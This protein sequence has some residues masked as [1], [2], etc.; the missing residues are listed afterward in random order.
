MNTIRIT[1]FKKFLVLSAIAIAL[2]APAR[3]GKANTILYGSTGD[4][5]TEGGGRL[6]LI[7][8]TAQTVT[9]IGD[10]GFGNL[11]GIAFDNSGVL[12]GVAGGATK[13][14][15]GTLMTIDPNTGA[16]TPIGTIGANIG[17][18]ALRFDSQNTLWGG[19]YDA[20]IT[21]GRLVTID[22]TNGNI[23]T[24]ITTSGSG[25]GLLPGLAFNSA[26]V[27]YGS[28]GG[29]FGHTE[30]VDLVDTTTGVLTP[31]PLAIADPSHP[32]SDL[33]FGSDGVLYG[34]SAFGQLYSID[35]TTGLLTF[36]F[37]T[38]ILKFSGLASQ[39][40]PGNS[41]GVPDA[42]SS[43]L[44]LGFALVA[45]IF[46]RRRLSLSN[47]LDQEILTDQPQT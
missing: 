28:R 6:Y 17:V 31:L 25:N 4:I 43:G 36:L 24:S 9:F 40:I 27:L 8:V 23:L 13:T 21:N 10:T 16:A 11:G 29:S 30:D 39:P 33:S 42:G 44:L 45:L 22:P 20:S 26:D 46:V 3:E 14:V 34:S 18:E 47:S 15:P 37:D 5:N 38:G 2:L 7:D 32:I 19:A 12:Y 41:Q 1:H 35:Q